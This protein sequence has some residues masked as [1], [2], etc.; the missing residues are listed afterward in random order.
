MPTLTA[1]PARPVGKPVGVNGHL[2]NEC[3]HCG[4]DISRYTKPRTN[5]EHREWRHE[6]SGSDCCDGRD[7]AL[8]HSPTLAAYGR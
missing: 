3:A 1:T 8:M 4:R 5:T 7:L 6:S 2:W